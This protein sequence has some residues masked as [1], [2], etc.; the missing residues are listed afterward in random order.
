MISGVL[1]LVAIP[2]LWRPYGTAVNPG[3]HD[4]D[5]GTALAITLGVVW[6]VVVAT[7]LI[8]HYLNKRADRATYAGG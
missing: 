3:L 8:R 1:T 4:R 7:G 6:L 5:Y 2:L